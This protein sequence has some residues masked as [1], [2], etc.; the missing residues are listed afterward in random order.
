M[1]TRLAAIPC[2]SGGIRL[3]RTI[4]LEGKDIS[5]FR[6]SIGLRRA[7][8]K[9][10]IG[11]YHAPADDN[12]GREELCPIRPSN[13]IR[14][15]KNSTNTKSCHCNQHDKARLYTADK[16][17]SSNG[18]AGARYRSRTVF[19]GRQKNGVSLKKLQE[20]PATCQRAS[21]FAFGRT[22]QK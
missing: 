1:F 7:L 22:D 14:G 4:T 20:L 5:L 16:E 13:R 21:M 9:E 12:T 3:D 2:C 11:A 6:V 17:A 8:G 19:C 10:K 18:C 15:K